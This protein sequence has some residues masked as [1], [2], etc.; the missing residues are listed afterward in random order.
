LGKHADITGNVYGLLTVLSASDNKTNDGRRKWICRCICGAI[1]EVAGRDLVKGNSSG[2]KS[3]GDPSHR[4][5][6]LTGNRYGQLLVVARVSSAANGRVYLCR[7][8]CGQEKEL[9]AAELRAR[10]H[11]SCAS[12]CGSNVAHGGSQKVHDVYGVMLTTKEMARLAG[13][14]ISSIQH[15]MQRTSDP[16]VW[17]CPYDMRL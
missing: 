6:D 1:K 4:M 3:C 15:R 9:R 10:R 12:G 7:C 5:E 16:R 8:D 2:T 17:L 13:V 14:S 11:K